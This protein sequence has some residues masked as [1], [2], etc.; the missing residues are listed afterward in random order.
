LN[1]SGN[2]IIIIISSNY[3]IEAPI[4]NRYQQKSKY[5][6]PK[7]SKKLCKPVRVYGIYGT[8]SDIFNERE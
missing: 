1:Y 2:L 8:I 3:I 6:K 5:G 7:K 4:K